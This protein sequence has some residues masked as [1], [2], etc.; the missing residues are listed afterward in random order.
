M[1]FNITTRSIAKRKHDNQHNY[2]QQQAIDIQHNNT[3]ADKTQHILKK[4]DTQHKRHSA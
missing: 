2:I 4:R 3:Q 1:T